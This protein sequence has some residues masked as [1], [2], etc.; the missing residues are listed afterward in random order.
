MPVSVVIPLYNKARHVRRAI[1]SVLNQTFQDFEVI[2]VDDG[3][4]D[5]GGEVVRQM[6]DPRIRLIVQDNAGVSAARNR[7]ILEAKSD[8]IA[9]LDADDEWLP[10]FLETVLGLRARHPGA[11]IYATAYRYCHGGNLW[12]PAFAHC[13]ELPEGGLLNDYFRAALGAQPVWASAVMFPKHIL[14]TVDGFPVGVA[15][16]EDLCVMARIALRYPVAWSPVVGATYH[17]SADNRACNKISSNLDF[18][19]AMEIEAAE[20]VSSASG[21][22]AP[23]SAAEYLA[24]QRL[25][26]ALN[27][28]FVGRIPA[29]WNLLRKTRCTVLFKRKRLFLHFLFYIPSGIT[30]LFREFK[31]S[32]YHG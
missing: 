3:S 5:G 12:Q 13:C 4:T 21:V 22:S 24:H 17:L 23:S 6:A 27:C 29:A 20:A 7:G 31:A 16:G 18:P 10:C 26:I 2:V 8:L 14:Q 19:A 30:R 25:Q 15:R 32:F 9:F 1:N 11:G 28:Y